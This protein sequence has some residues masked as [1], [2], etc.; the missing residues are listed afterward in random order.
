MYP[1]QRS[2][3]WVK[4]HRTLI[5]ILVWTL[6][7]LIGMSQLAVSETSTFVH[8]HQRYTSCGERWPPESLAGQLYTLFIFVL[9]FALPMLVLCVVYTTMGCRL[10][11]HKV[12]GERTQL[13]VFSSGGTDTGTA[14]NTSFREERRKSSKFQVTLDAS[15][16]IGN[17][18]LVESKC[19]SSNGK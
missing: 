11:R 4:Q 10:L 7:T 5:L 16:S 15:T 3:S 18:L 2:I 14:A 17:R 12:P 1:L 8:D 9:T 6:G 13:R 19:T